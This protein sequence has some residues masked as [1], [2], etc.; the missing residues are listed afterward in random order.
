MF[1]IYLSTIE[2]N[3][4]IYIYT[5]VCVFMRL[6]EY[7]FRIFVS[8]YLKRMIE[9]VKRLDDVTLLSDASMRI[10]GRASQTRIASK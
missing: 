7:S 1:L 5:Q 10:V 9:S 6:R 4:Y 3:A 8:F 2:G